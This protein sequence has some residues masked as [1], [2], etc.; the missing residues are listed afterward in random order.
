MSR[1][2]MHR[3]ERGMLARVS[4]ARDMVVVGAVVVF[5][6]R[7]DGDGNGGQVNDE[8]EVEGRVRTEQ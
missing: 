4:A 7:E 2:M 8:A 6:F 5:V 1:P 3:V